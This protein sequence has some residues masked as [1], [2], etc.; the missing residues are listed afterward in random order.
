[1]NVFAIGAAFVAGVGV[2]IFLCDWMLREATDVL[3]KAKALHEQSL[4]MLTKRRG[5]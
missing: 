4:A 5:V 3:A 2:G 1:V